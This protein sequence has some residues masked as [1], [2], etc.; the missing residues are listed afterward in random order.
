MRMLPALAITSLP[1]ETV[2]LDTKGCATLRMGA[3]GDDVMSS[4][5]DLLFSWLCVCVQEDG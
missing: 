4:L 5:V 3:C 2:T 1:D